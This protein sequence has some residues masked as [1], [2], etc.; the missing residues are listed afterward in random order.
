MKPLNVNF[1]TMVL[2]V[3]R[4]AEYSSCQSCCQ[5]RCHRCT[6]HSTPIR[7][8][9]V[10]IF[11]KNGKVISCLPRLWVAIDI[12]RFV[13]PIAGEYTENLMYQSRRIRNPSLKVTPIGC[14]GKDQYTFPVGF[15]DSVV[16]IVIMFRKTS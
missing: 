9:H 10:D 15:N 8:I 2:C 11:A 5:G 16:K 13:G 14:S 6:T 7:C 1:S 12:C 4:E 3:P